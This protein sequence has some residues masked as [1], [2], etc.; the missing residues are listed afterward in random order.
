MP[1]GDKPVDYVVPHCKRANIQDG[2]YEK[3]AGSWNGSTN[4]RWRREFAGSEDLIP[5]C[6]L[7]Y[8]GFPL[9]NYVRT[10]KLT[11]ENDKDITQYLRKAQT[12]HSQSKTPSE[13]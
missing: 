11:A 5:T 7:R 9:H 2:I 3:E 8:L 1:L 6:S 12:R 4:E 13:M 10:V